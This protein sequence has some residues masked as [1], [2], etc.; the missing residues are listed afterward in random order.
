MEKSEFCILSLDAGGT[1]FVFSALKNENQIGENIIT[2]SYGD[3]LD[4]S[5]KSIISGF[6]Q[7]A[8]QVEN[9]FHAI[10]FAFPG[11]SDY[12]HGIIGD[13]GNLPAYRGGVALGPMLE[14]H[15]KVPVFINNDGDLFTFGEAFAGALPE[16]NK[17]VKT[18]DSKKQYKNLIGITLGTGFGLGV[19]NDGKMLRG[20][21]SMPAEVW[22]LRNYPDNTYNIEESISIRGI[23]RNYNQEIQSN[24]SI[25]PLGIY[26]I[27][28]GEMQGNKLAAIKAFESFGESLGDTMA[29]LISIF[30]ANLVIGGG[31]AG[32]WD[33][34]MPSAM[35]AMK[36]EFI[37]PEAQKIP[38]L[39]H[40]VFNLENDKE[41]VKFAAG[42][43]TEI[44]IPFSNER[45]NYDKM[46]RVGVIK[47]R[48]G[49]SNAVS[50]G[51][52]HFAISKLLSDK[53]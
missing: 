8:F 30:D 13:L 26:K 49:T 51:A 20:D 32:A 52:Y 17:R 5:L 31:L 34:F 14:K 50:L 39:T 27:A 28:I 10:S 42:E 48:L 23:V 38:R 53:A 21:N 24:E 6:V 4:Q 36:S 43:Q 41:F 44:S 45:M 16:I 19:V 22:L 33:L 25:N 47:S 3:N 12:E 18:L 9:K 1:N 15:F 35:K 46:S 11:P 7:L 29:S 40:Q 37:T 2:P